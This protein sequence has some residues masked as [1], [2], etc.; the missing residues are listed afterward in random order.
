MVKKK[1]AKKDSFEQRTGEGKGVS[2][3]DLWG[4]E[5]QERKQQV[6]CLQD[7]NI[8]NTFEKQ[9]EGWC[10]WRGMNEWER[11]RNRTEGDGQK[12]TNGRISCQEILHVLYPYGV[13][14]NKIK[15]LL[16]DSII[17]PPFLM[18]P[19]FNLLNY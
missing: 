12:T 2:H 7:R 4:R 15:L 9:Y 17:L 3:V 6:L 10:C 18:S 11:S 8:P 14:L 16:S 19:S 1:V 5:F 13:F